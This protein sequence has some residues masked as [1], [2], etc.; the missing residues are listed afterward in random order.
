MKRTEFSC[1][2]KTR[3]ATLAFVS[4]AA[5]SGMAATPA[6]AQ[7]FDFP[8][9]EQALAD[10]ALATW[11][12]LALPNR[13]A[14]FVS[15]GRFKGSDAE[16]LYGQIGDGLNPYETSP[17]YTELFGG[18]QSFDPVLT[19]SDGSN[20]TTAN[21]EWNSFSVTGGFGWDFEIDEYWTLRPIANISFGNVQAEVDP[22]SGVNSGNSGSG[23]DFLR[24]GELWTMG[25]GAALELQYKLHAPNREFD[26]YLRHTEMKLETIGDSTVDADADV[27]ATTAW[28]RAR[29][30]I[31]NW[32]AYGRPVRSVWQAGVA[33]LYGD[34]DEALGFDWVASLG[35]GIELDVEETSLPWVKRARVMLG[36]SKSDVFDVYS[37]GFGISF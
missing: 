16:L 28:L 14:R 20:T 37:I 7:N 30:P 9:G 10:Q 36:Y 24:N 8:G 18:Y 4:A 6:G 1:T 11:G 27:S 25:Y 31:R 12:Y 35:A 34:Q 3:L 26:F 19:L 23:V 33:G 2:A 13:A 32:R 5:M 15:A 21:A 22:I 17:F 29:Y